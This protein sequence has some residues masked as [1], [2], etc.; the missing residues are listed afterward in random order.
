M[1]LS[2]LR[3]LNSS[4]I[5]FFHFFQVSGRTKKSN[6]QNGTDPTINTFF[7]IAIVGFFLRTK[8][9]REKNFWSVEDRTFEENLSKKELSKKELSKKELSKKELSKENFRRK[10]FRRKNVRRKNVRRK[11][12]KVKTFEEKTFEEKTFEEKTMFRRITFWLSGKSG[13]GQVQILRISVSTEKVFG[14]IFILE[15][16]HEI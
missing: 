3:Y 1:F 10:N 15:F 6:N 16:S 14:Q 9:D 7:S 11:T 8:R 2:F 5:D 4:S 13:D 12:F